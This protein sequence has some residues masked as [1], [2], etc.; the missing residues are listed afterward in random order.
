[1]VFDDTT[2]ESKYTLARM[3]IRSGTQVSTRTTQVISKLSTPTPEDSSPILVVLQA[4]NRDANKLITVTEI[5]KRELLLKGIKTFQYTALSSQMIDVERKPAPRPPTANAA[6]DEDGEISDDAF[7]TVGEVDIKALGPKKRAVPVLTVYL[8]T[9][10]VK[11][12]KAEFGNEDEIDGDACIVIIS[13]R[14]MR[15]AVYHTGRAVN[16]S[17]LK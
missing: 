4:N 6:G 5:A 3:R 11:E 15:D 7:Q 17:R 14:T 13:V 2:L 8:A 9:K 10:P 1:M 12:L 16:R